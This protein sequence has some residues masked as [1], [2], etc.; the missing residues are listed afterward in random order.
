MKVVKPT[1]KQ[2]TRASLE[3]SKTFA[4]LM[5]EKDVLLRSELKKAAQ[6]RGLWDDKK[7]EELD[8]VRK[9]ILDGDAQLKRG[10]KTLDGKS[11]SR[12]Q[13]KKLAL[14]MMDWRSEFLNLNS[15]LTEFEGFTCETQ[16]EQAEFDYICSVCILND[17]DTPRF[18]DIN[19]YRAASDEEEVEVK[20]GELS[21]L[22]SDY[23]PN[24]YN[25]LPEINF[26]MKYKFIND[27]HQLI[28][29]DGQLVNGTGHRVDKDG[30]L[31]NEQGEL[32]N[33]YGE[34]VDK[35]GNMLEFV[36]FVD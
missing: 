17:D 9:K 21:A 28:D 19:E 10:G 18:A 12:A 11:F 32:V 33:D 7:Q 24:W 6:D 26:L 20:A 25:Q 4:R 29:E 5:R 27:E 15:V 3:K 2:K 34:K 36:E 23:D 14:D 8:A 22:I 30:Q 1:M 16:S 35:D 31:I 13:A